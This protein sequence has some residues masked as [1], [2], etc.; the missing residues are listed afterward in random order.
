MRTREQHIAI[1]DRILEAYR[2]QYGSYQTKR[3]HYKARDEW[4]DSSEVKRH[5][6][7]LAKQRERE[8][9]KKEAR[10]KLKKKSSVPVKQ[11]KPMFEDTNKIAAQRTMGRSLAG[12]TFYNIC[13]DDPRY[14]RTIY[15]R[16]NPFTNAMQP[17]ISNPVW[18]GKEDAENAG[19]QPIDKRMLASMM[20]LQMRG[21]FRDC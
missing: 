18:G 6:D 12:Q 8:K 2:R 15:I 16:F 19:L 13:E 9:K 20:R 11:G 5:N 1:A 17:M 10:E 7:A 21:D 4:E 3:G 14:Y